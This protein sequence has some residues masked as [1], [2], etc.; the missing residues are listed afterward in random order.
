MSTLRII[1][2]V[3]GKHE[4]YLKII[5]DCEYSIQ[6]GD[7]G[8]DYSVLDQVDPKRHKIIPGNHD[9]YDEVDKYE[10]FLTTYGPVSF[11][12]LDFFY[13][14]GAFSIDNCFRYDNYLRGGIKT[15][16]DNEELSLEELRE[17]IL[18]YS[19]NKPEIVISHECPAGLIRGGD[20]S[21]YGYSDKFDSRTQI[22]M[23]VMFEGHHPEKW[24]FGHWHKS[25][26][27]NIGKTK[28]CCLEEL[29]F[30][31]FLT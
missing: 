21:S 19:K 6:V 7:F 9:N 12:G 5:K 13:I 29:D 28:F 14:R 1:G 16:W 23:K 10:H 31:D 11:A 27:K 25:L 2:D 24:F 20:L 17:C 26:T 30:V 3:H 15:V 22:A 18:S 4:D 8:F